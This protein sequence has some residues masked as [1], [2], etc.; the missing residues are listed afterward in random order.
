MTIVVSD[1]QLPWFHV[2]TGIV[3]SN[4]NHRGFRCTDRA[5]RLDL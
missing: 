4:A 2:Q 3:V 1:A 5:K